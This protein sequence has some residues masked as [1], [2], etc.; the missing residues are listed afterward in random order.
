MNRP[1]QGCLTWASVAA[2][3]EASLLSSP[4][5]T[6]MP[7]CAAA[8]PAVAGPP[9]PASPPSASSRQVRY[10]KRVGDNTAIKF[11]TDGILLR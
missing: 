10:D 9:H 7:R 3:L 1:F 2:C 8:G 5:R 11:M 4:G 6:N